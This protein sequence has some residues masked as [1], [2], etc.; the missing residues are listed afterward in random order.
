[1][2]S[3]ALYERQQATI[4]LYQQ[5][6]VAE[7]ESLDPAITKINHTDLMKKLRSRIHGETSSD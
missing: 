6:A 7:K 3:H 4:E 1:M 2:M 5:L